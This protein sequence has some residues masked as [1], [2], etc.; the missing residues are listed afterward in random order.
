MS[1]NKVVS[2]TVG[3]GDGVGAASAVREELSGAA[4]GGGGNIAVQQNVARNAFRPATTTSQYI[5]SVQPNLL[6]TS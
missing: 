6:W 1:D 4:G 2:G 3:G 5:A